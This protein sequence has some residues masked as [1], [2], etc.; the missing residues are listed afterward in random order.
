LGA[1]ISALHFLTTIP[2]LPHRPY[3]H[4]EMGRAVGIFPLVGLLI[5]AILVGVNYLLA[6]IFPPSLVSALLLATWIALTGA[7][8]LDGFLDACDGLLGG[9]DV[10]S[11]LE[12]MRDERIGAFAFA[13]GAMLL[14][15]K[16]IALDVTPETTSALWL[17][18][19][20]GRW[21]MSLAIA[22]FPYARKKGLGRGFKDYTTWRQV[23]LSTI[24][25]LAVAILA[26][27]WLGLIVFGVTALTVWLCARFVM[28]RIPGLTGD[29]YGA[30]CE[31]IEVVVLLALA[32]SLPL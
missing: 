30:I 7:L 20:M 10:E 14:L 9:H 6:L 15:I 32:V 18:P 21:G 27:Q 4:K 24:I 1:L 23:A 2:W 8:H 29:I 3:S 11:H 17:A 25:A 5:G 13:G 22:F 19:V 28:K 31:I 12:I 26:A 16:F